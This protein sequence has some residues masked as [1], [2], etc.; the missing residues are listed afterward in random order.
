MLKSS[1]C[2]CPSITVV[3][4]A[5]CS[6]V[7]AEVLTVTVSPSASVKEKT[8]AG[9]IR[10]SSNSRLAARERWRLSEKRERKAEWLM[11]VRLVP[12]LSSPF[13]RERYSPDRKKSRSAKVPADF[14]LREIGDPSAHA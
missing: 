7:P 12:A 10:A 13:A 11:D 8:A 2:N 9:A 6:L 14:L 4:V 3:P 5:R 1:F